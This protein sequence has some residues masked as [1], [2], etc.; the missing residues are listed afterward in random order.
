MQPLLAAA[1][2]SWQCG[3]KFP[4]IDVEKI[5]KGEPKELHVFPSDE[6]DCPTVLW[7][8]LSNKNFKSLENY[9]QKSKESRTNYSSVKFLLMALNFEIVKCRVFIA[10]LFV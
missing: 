3:L 2:H 6:D 4:K 10:T 7:F 5:E 8:T 1:A 9:K